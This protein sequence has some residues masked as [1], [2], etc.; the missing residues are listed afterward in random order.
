MQ[1]RTQESFFFAMVGAGA[2][3]QLLIFIIFFA[4]L[5]Q[6]FPEILVGL[7]HLEIGKGILAEFTTVSIWGRLGR[8]ESR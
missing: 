6:A 1:D 7:T 4:G 3:F 2:V 5:R 8:A